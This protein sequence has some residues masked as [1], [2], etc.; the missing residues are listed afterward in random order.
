MRFEPRA[1]RARRVEKLFA[2]AV[3]LS[4][5]ERAEILNRAYRR[6][7]KSVVRCIRCEK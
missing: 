3:R 1:S 7:N 2:R 5:A 4:P 6:L